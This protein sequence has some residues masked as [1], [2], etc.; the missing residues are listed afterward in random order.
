[1]N[2]ELRRLDDFRFFEVE[3]LFSDGNARRSMET[4]RGLARDKAHAQEL[5]LDAIWEPR[6]TA[7]GCA[8]VYSTQEL[9][10]YL[11]CEGWGHYFTEAHESHTRWVLDRATEKLVHAEVSGK[12]LKSVWHPMSTA[13]KS[14]L[15]Q[16]LLHAND[17]LRDFS[18]FEIEESD[19]LPAWAMPHGSKADAPPDALTQRTQ[20]T[21]Q[22]EL[23]AQRHRDA[24]SE[25]SFSDA[26]DAYLDLRAQSSNVT[27]G[28]SDKEYFNRRAALRWRMDALAPIPANP[29]AAPAIAT[30]LASPAAR[31]PRP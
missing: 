2:T 26:L 14:D 9:E 28:Y 15:L 16:S 18:D 20:T 8:P 1:M 6:L 12:V 3:V 5:A 7:G 19:S 11:V 25:L 22:A 30:Q 27:S 23:G 29:A 10:R 17:I 24:V 31:R 13:D 21:N 4:W